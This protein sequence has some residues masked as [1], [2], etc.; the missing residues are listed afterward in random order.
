MFHSR[1][2]FSLTLNGFGDIFKNERERESLYE[3]LY[4][5]KRAHECIYIIYIYTYTYCIL[6]K[7]LIGCIAWRDG[8]E[9]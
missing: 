4:I 3:D 2:F 6:S 1:H 7:D 5:E 8:K 9:E